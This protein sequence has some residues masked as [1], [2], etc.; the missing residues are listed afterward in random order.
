MDSSNQFLVVGSPGRFGTGRVKIIT[1]VPGELT[2]E[3]A[4]NLAA[5]LLVMSGVE[6]DEFQR[7][8]GEIEKQPL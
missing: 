7:L 3:Q 6:D 5:W 8:V 1:P 2:K 4:A